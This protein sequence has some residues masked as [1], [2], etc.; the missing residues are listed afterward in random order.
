[1]YMA[2]QWNPRQ[3]VIAA[4]VRV[5]NELVPWSWLVNRDELVL[6]DSNGAPIRTLFRPPSKGVAEIVGIGWS[7]EGRF[8]LCQ[9]RETDLAKGSATTQLWL[10]DTLA[11]SVWQIEAPQLP[12][13][14]R[15]WIG[16]DGQTVG[17]RG[18]LWARASGALER[19]SSGRITAISPQGREAVLEDDVL[20]V[21]DSAGRL[22]EVYR[23]SEDPPIHLEDLAWAPNGALLAV[24]VRYRAEPFHNEV[25]VLRPEGGLPLILSTGLPIASLS[26]SPDGAELLGITAGFLPRRLV[27]L[28]LPAGL[29]SG[30]AEERDGLPAPSTDAQGLLIPRWVP[31]GMPSRPLVQRYPGGPMALDGFA[32][33]T[34]IYSASFTRSLEVDLYPEAP[35][36]WQDGPGKHLGVPERPVQTAG[37]MAYLALLERGYPPRSLGGSE[38]LL[39]EGRARMRLDGTYV[40]VRWRGLSEGEVLKLLSSML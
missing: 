11:G 23:G 7:P 30:P 37:G 38:G 3:Q 10:A 9:V 34:L 2:A 13:S 20:Y 28:P 25:V 36:W 22:R 24:S 5:N 33:V 19:F 26:W 6:L 8:V 15:L 32:H 4:V 17:G 18:F 35:G 21:R 40:V 29:G 27:R 1:M 31:E 39:L 16:P 14:A 12:A